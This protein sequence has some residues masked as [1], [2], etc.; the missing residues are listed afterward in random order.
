[1]YSVGLDVGDRCSSVEILNPD[2]KHVKY[3]EIKGH[4][5]AMLQRV[6]QEVPR[7]FAVCF[8]AS[9]GYGH[10]YEELS[11]LSP[12]VSVAHPGQL[13]LIFKSKRKHN[14]V[15]AKKLAKLLYLDEVPQVHVPKADVRSWRGT[16]QWRQKLLSRRVA[17]KNQVRSLLKSQGIQVGVK[18]LW[19]K[20]G[21]G[22][23]GG[24][25]LSELEALR[26]DMLIDDLK[27]LTAKIKRVE[28]YLAKVAGGHPGVALLMTIPGVGIRTAEAAMAYVD[29]VRRFAR[30]KQVGCYF[31]LVP[32]EDSS[33]STNRLGHITRDG[34]SA[35]RK[36]LT[37]AAW[38]GIRRSPTIRAFFQRVMHG[39]PD[40][41]KIAL[42]A[43]AHWLVRVI[44]SMLRSGE[45]WR[46]REQEKLDL[47]ERD[48]MGRRP[49]GPENPQAAAL[50]RR[51]QD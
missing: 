17:V 8:E 35:V 31:G 28:K 33:G 14:R 37:E 34:P 9:C 22:W 4:W 30:L 3:L 7:P 51:G 19:T 43:T 21:L 45:C 1:M 25:Q 16:I 13:R 5:P 47:L 18:G 12:H 39:D 49:R 15:D 38:Q 10:L 23:L 40:R 11:K 24:L 36:L 44:A 6:A 26:R 29:G 2:G 27:D 20:R 41:K 32:C 42:V 46:E 48:S 50:A